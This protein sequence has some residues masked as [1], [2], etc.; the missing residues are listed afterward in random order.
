[1]AITPDFVMTIGGRQ[2]TDKLMSWVLS[3]DDDSTGS[4]AVK[5]NNHDRLL[6][7]LFHLNQELQIFFGYTDNPG[8]RVTFWVKG[9]GGGFDNG[10]IT[11]NVTAEDATCDLDRK[12]AKGHLGEGVKPK[13]AIAQV[14]AM[15]GPAGKPLKVI[16]EGEDPPMAS[17]M[18]I[19]W[20]GYAAGEG[21]RS[22]ARMLYYPGYKT[23][24]PPIQHA[25]IYAK[26]PTMII[27]TRNL[28][29]RDQATFYV[30]DGTWVKSFTWNLSQPKNKG[31]GKGV[32]GHSSVKDNRG[33]GASAGSSDSGGGGSEE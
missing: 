17:H 6:S 1:M 20:P 23:G 30:G 4:I 21:I 2:V 19:P 25:D 13:G 26:Q 8:E 28:A 15:A 32:K 5:L 27:G 22:L 10:V 12:T 11:L 14:A 24:A 29:A 33:R 7:G 16:I 18:R 31:R 3:H 9:V